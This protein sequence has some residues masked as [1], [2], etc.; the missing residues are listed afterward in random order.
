MNS[1]R[2]ITREKNVKQ[3]AHEYIAGTQAN[4]G[5]KHQSMHTNVQHLYKHSLTHTLNRSPAP[6]KFE[7][8]QTGPISS[9]FYEW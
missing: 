6:I 4:E 2:N 7:S 8:F 9:A 3:Q 1:T 5:V